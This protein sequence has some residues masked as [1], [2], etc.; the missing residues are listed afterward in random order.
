MRLD[1]ER[2]EKEEAQK[3]LVL[4]KEQSLQME[5]QKQPLAKDF[6]S[7]EKALEKHKTVQQGRMEVG[8]AIFKEANVKLAAAMKNKGF[9]AVSVAQAMIKVA[10]KRSA[11]V[12]LGCWKGGAKTSFKTKSKYNK[13]LL[14]AK[15][16]FTFSLVILRPWV[17]IRPESNSRSPA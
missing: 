15:Q 13:H 2:K 5:G 8:K 9:K 4:Q 12:T 6:Q 3:Q 7:K 10:Q 16:A 17:M 1:K 14:T 11:V